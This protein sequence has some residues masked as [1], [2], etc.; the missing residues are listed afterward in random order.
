M[1]K[2][3]SGCG[4]TTDEKETKQAVLERISSESLIHIA[5]YGMGK[6]Q[7]LPFRRYHRQQYV[8]GSLNLS[9]QVPPA[10]LLSRLQE[11]EHL[12]VV[13][14]HPLPFLHIAM[15]AANQP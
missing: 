10:S 5:A 4:R 15:A 9:A 8:S 7:F 13:R 6:G 2:K 1:C 11:A 3:G 12:P 14:P